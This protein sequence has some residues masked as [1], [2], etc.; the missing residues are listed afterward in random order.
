MV[1][2]WD[3]TVWSLLVAILVLCY[4][5]CRAIRTLMTSNLASCPSI[6]SALFAAS[7]SSDLIGPVL[8]SRVSV[9]RS[10][11]DL[12]D[13]SPG[14]QQEND[15]RETADVVERVVL[16]DAIHDVPQG[17]A[18]RVIH[19]GVATAPALALPGLKSTSPSPRRVPNSGRLSRKAAS[20]HLKTRPALRLQRRV[21]ETSS[22]PPGGIPD[23]PFDVCIGN[24]VVEVLISTGGVRINGLRLEVP[25]A[26]LGTTPSSAKPS[27]QISGPRS[28][29]APRGG[30]GR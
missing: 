6:S 13:A 24:L 10:G 2:T 28:R 16:D 26:S 11:V 17:P 22:T 14:I 20:A 23:S 19:R 12:C 8:A 9:P 1:L 25:S 4:T 3:P 18:S 21:R 29:H 15:E 30:P 5:I 27:S 7:G